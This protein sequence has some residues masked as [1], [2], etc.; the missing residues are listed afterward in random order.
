MEWRAIYIYIYKVA[1]CLVLCL[2]YA[3]FGCLCAPVLRL[4]IFLGSQIQ[5]IA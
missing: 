5:L 1:V 3:A 2:G 4:R